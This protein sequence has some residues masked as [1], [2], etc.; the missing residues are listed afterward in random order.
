MMAI[1]TMLQRQGVLLSLLLLTYV[2]IVTVVAAEDSSATTSYIDV[3]EVSSFSPDGGVESGYLFRVPLS[4]STFSNLPPMAPRWS[5]NLA[6][7]ADDGDRSGNS[8]TTYPSHRLLLP[9]ES[10]MYLCYESKGL[11]DYSDPSGNT[12]IF[13]PDTMLSGYEES[14][15]LIPRGHCSFESKTR[16]A[17]RLGA[18]GVV[19]RNTLDSYYTLIDEDNVN[20][21]TDNEG[22]ALPSWSNTQWPIEK[23][24]YE[25]GTNIASIGWRAN[26]DPTLL[27]FD[28]PPYGEFGRNNMILTGPAVDGNLCALS[29]DAVT[30]T[31][32]YNFDS[33]CPSKRCLLTGRNST[34][35]VETSETTNDEHYYMEAC[36]AWDVL[37]QMSSDGDN[38]GD[39]IPMYNEEEIT[40]ASLFVTMEKGDE[41]Y[42]LIV[43]ADDYNAASD[44][45]VRYINIVPYARWYPVV[46]HYSM[47]LLWVLAVFTLWVSTYESAKEYRHSWKKISQAIDDGILVWQRI[48]GDTNA[49]TS[50]AGG[51]SNRPRAGTDETID[52]Y[53]EVM[54]LQFAPGEVEMTTTSSSMTTTTPP[55]ANIFHV[56]GNDDTSSRSIISTDVSTTTPSTRHLVVESD[57]ASPVETRDENF[58]IED[59]NDDDS[60]TETVNKSTADYENNAANDNSTA[61]NDGFAPV[62][63]FRP[64]TEE[65]ISTVPQQQQADSDTR[66]DTST[67][68]KPHRI[69]LFLINALAGISIFCIFVFGVDKVLR[70]LYAIVGSIAVKKN[71]IILLY[72]MVATN[73]LSDEASKKL[74]SS[75]FSGWKWI[76]ILSAVPCGVLGITWMA[77]GLFLVQPDN[78]FYWV[79]QDIM[80]VCLCILILE[81]IRFNNILLPTV[82]LILLFFYY[83][84]FFVIM[85]MIF[86]TSSV[87]NVA[88]STVNTVYCE[89]YPS[90]SYCWGTLAPFPFVLLI[91]RFNDFRGGYALPLN[92]GVILFPGL[93][94]SFLARYDSAKWL[95]SKCSQ[96]RTIDEEVMSE[97]RSAS[98]SRN[99]LKRLRK[100]LFSRYFGP[101]CIAYSIGLLGCYVSIS[102]FKMRQPELIYIVPSCIGTLFFLGLWRRALSEL[103]TGPKVM[104]KADRMIELA[105]KIPQAQF[106]ASMEASNNLAETSSVI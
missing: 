7:T 76:D 31:R 75:A 59:V 86:G 33:Q 83:M 43:N 65:A 72:E 29:G 18:V 105:G 24:D 63:S 106:A 69:N 14:Y 11:V 22:H 102:V 85:P 95:V 23:K 61:S 104:M 1:G 28:P 68:A 42:D 3:H 8:D 47:I 30:A 15:I 19:I 41:L 89:R 87:L 50:P 96:I 49:T 36:C 16:S 79:Y 26:V 35:K 2:V 64:E 97:E 57:I 51:G 73:F 94:I 25:C 81:Q 71:A 93:L 44:G 55:A 70:I 92:L 9:P 91:P 6:L 5:S 101:L 34:I 88:S 54:V 62:G 74:N 82:I 53:D 78:V 17:Q 103:W 80:G 100:A 58:V 67:A 48:D 4:S 27:L 90:D 39:L 60:P 84:S 10:D 56:H 38:D 13:D 45:S 66:S 98:Q 32:S 37:L 46:Q 40:I 21:I 12:N 99:I 77:L 20:V 52:S